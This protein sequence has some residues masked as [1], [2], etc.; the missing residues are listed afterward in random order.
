MAYARRML[1]GDICREVCALQGLPVPTAVASNGNDVTARQMW[2]QLRTQGRRL[3]KPQRTHRW[4]TLVREWVLVTQPAKTLYDLPADWDSFEDLTGWN[5]SSRMPM[6]GPASDVQWQCLKARSMG[7]TI[8]VIYRHI[9]D[10]I[11]IYGAPASAQQLHITYSSRAWVRQANSPDPSNPLYADAPTQ[12]GD[13]VMLDPE[14]MVAA[15]QYGFMGAKGF[16]TT[17][18]AGTLD[19]LIEAAIDADTDAPVLNAATSDAYPYV[20]VFFNLPD[21]GYGG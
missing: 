18:I 12:D 4:R 21:S 16:D 13:T 10:Q 7:S 11:E 3:C 6:M 17:T 2:A 14:M 15:V 9:G 8:G 19:K 20:N 1:A 5:F